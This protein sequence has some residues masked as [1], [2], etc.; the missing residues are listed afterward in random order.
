[1]ARD[2][3]ED[4]QMAEIEIWLEEQGWIRHGPVTHGDHQQEWFKRVACAYGHAEDKP[5]V[6]LHLR[7]W[8]LRDTAAVAGV[9]CED[10]TPG[11]DV[12]IAHETPLGGVTLRGHHMDNDNVIERLPKWSAYLLQC[13]SLAHGSIPRPPATGVPWQQPMNWRGTTTGRFSSRNEPSHRYADTGDADGSDT[14]V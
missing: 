4:I 6:Q 13:W 3:T 8:D 9:P 7:Y 2:M 12:A 11:W 10:V 5:W 1:M 14:S